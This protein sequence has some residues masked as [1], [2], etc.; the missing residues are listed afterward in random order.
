[1][2]SPFSLFRRY[3]RL[4]LAVVG[5]LAMIAFVFLTPILQYS[6]ESAEGPNEPIV[7]SKYGSINDRALSGMVASRQI[8]KIFLQRVAVATA[9]ALV[10]RNEIPPEQEGEAAEFIFQN[11][12]QQLMTRSRDDDE[13]AVIETM[14]LANK[15]RGLGVL[16]SDQAINEFLKQITRNSVSA[17]ELSRLIKELQYGERRVSQNRLFEALRTEL[18]A[19]RFT[20]MYT[21]GLRVIPP[22][23][24]FDYF[25]RLSRK[26]TIEYAPVVVSTLLDKV[27]EPSKAEVQAF[28]ERYRDRL[29]SPDSPEPGFKQPHRA[30]WE[31]LKAN[32]DALVEKTDVSED[33]IRKYY[34]A[35]KDQFK[36]TEFPGEG[37]E[38]PMSTSEPELPKSSEEAGEATPPAAEPGAEKSQTGE[39]QTEKPETPTGTTPAGTTPPAGEEPPQTPPADGG[40]S[41]RM[42]DKRIRPNRRLSLSRSLRPDRRPAFC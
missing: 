42:T 36:I 28:Y 37:S 38:K 12:V 29:P 4:M 18:L 2:A 11:A 22:A 20:L 15:A 6:G 23:Q 31:Y 13:H 30:A 19:S 7:E 25:S 8:V 5:V 3:Q 39:T 10:A 1:M 9:E 35:N 32:Y 40:S 21:A 17:S 14:I 27:R 41:K 26:A 16:V 24:R 33:E 34:E